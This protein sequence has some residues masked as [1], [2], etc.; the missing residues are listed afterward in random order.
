MD[1]QVPNRSKVSTSSERD[2]RQ[3]RARLW[4]QWKELA[5]RGNPQRDFQEAPDDWLARTIYGHLRKLVTRGQWRVLEVIVEERRSLDRGRNSIRG[6]PFKSGLIALLGDQIEMKPNRR[7]E[8]SD[9]M[10]YAFMHRVQTKHFNGFVKQAGQ[11]QIRRK[12]QSGFVEP[13]FD[14]AA[15]RPRPYFVEG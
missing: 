1:G 3:K 11:K 6:M 7:A 5:D 8:F 12:I 2:F 14:P 9:A 15:L 10:E 4:Q 13:G